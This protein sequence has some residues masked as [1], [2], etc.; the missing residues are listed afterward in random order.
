MMERDSTL[1]KT[2]LE[3]SRFCRDQGT[4]SQDA[5]AEIQRHCESKIASNNPEDRSGTPESVDSEA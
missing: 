4:M 3:L 5:F 1:D 2:I